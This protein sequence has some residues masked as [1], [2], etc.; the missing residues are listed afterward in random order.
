ME[1]KIKVQVGEQQFITTRDT[2]IGESSYFAALLSGRWNSQGN[3]EFFIDSDPTLFTEVLRYLRS[4]NFPLFFDPSLCTYDYARYT[5]LLGEAQYFGIP[6]LENWIRMQGYLGAVKIKY[7]IG[8]LEEAESGASLEG[9]YC[10]IKA[11]QRLDFSFLSRTKSIY[12]CPRRV[13]VHEGHPEKC[14]RQCDKAQGESE[15]KYEDKQ[16]ITAVIVK[17][18]QL[19]NPEVCLGENAE[20]K[21]DGSLI[22]GV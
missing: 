20:P 22:D 2:L 6:K 3:D 8:L 4:G 11:D 13:Q 1:N 12:Q 15:P 18:E 16:L 10:T 19:F 14:G 9:H 17:T 5:A 21:G 7:S